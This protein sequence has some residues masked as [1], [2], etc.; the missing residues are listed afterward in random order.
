MSIVMKI[1]PKLILFVF[2]FGM[3]NTFIHATEMPTIWHRPDSLMVLP[4][5]DAIEWTDSYTIFSVVR[6]LQ[7]NTNQC[8]WGFL[9]NDSIAL[10]VLTHGI[11]KSSFGI[12]P[13]GRAR[14]FSKWSIYAYH[15]GLRVDSANHLSLSLGSQYYFSDSTS[16]DTLSAQIEL[17]EFAY[18]NGYVSHRAS[19]SFQTYLALK[20]GITLDYA[21][22]LSP[23]GDTLWHPERD[24]LYYHRI[25]G[26]G[27]DTIHQWQTCSSYSKEQS[28]L[29]LYT[30]TLGIG[31]Y[32]LVGDDGGELEWQHTMEEHF[33][34]HRKWR[35]RQYVEHPKT[36]HFAFKLPMTPVVEDSLWLAILDEY[37]QI[38]R[39]ILPDSIV[40]DSVG[41]F[42]IHNP[43]VIMHLQL[44]AI[45]SPVMQS[46]NKTSHKCEEELLGGT[47]VYD[48]QNRCI[49][50]DGYPAEQLFELHLYDNSGKL[51]STIYSKNPIDISI[52]PRTIFYIEI[53]TLGQIVGSITLPLTL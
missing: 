25:V 19:S 48:T 5:S 50:I 7:P 37:E 53:T 21:A 36:L 28:S 11:Y 38:K 34:L 35:V 32:I 1:N 31:E 30:D 43:D 12:L 51:H 14:D 22:Y 6:S 29:Y 15:S 18:Y 40:G 9:E 47:I 13:I 33:I 52:Y 46:L 44:N 8:L 23:L 17:E 24:E 4:Q 26:L 39:T 10:A 27:Y 3:L 20:Y 45:V 49:I 42:T 16:I 2:L 41:Y